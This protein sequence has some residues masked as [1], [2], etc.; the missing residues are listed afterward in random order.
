LLQQTALS[1]SIGLVQKPFALTKIKVDALAQRITTSCHSD[2]MHRK[3]LM[4]GHEFNVQWS[5]ERHQ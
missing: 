2:A 5:T 1:V 3:I 4:E